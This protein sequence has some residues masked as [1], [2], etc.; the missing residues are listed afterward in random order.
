MNRTGV[1]RIKLIALSI[2]LVA[3]GVSAVLI[4]RADSPRF[5]QKEADSMPEY[6]GK[7]NA[8][9]FP[10]GMEWL[11]TDHPISL[12]Q[13]RGKVV[14]LDFWTYCCINCMH[15]LPD[16]KKLERKY[17]NELVVIGVHSAKFATEK[18]TENI[19]QA[20]L[21]Y[22]I[23]HPVVNDKD[24]VIWQH[25]A[26]RAWPTL[27]VIDPLGKIIGYVSGEG[28]Y[29]AFDQLIGQVVK[30]FDPRGLMNHEPIRFNLER[31]HVPASIL[32]FPGKVLADE[33]SKRLFIADSNHN[34]IVVTALDGEIQ[35]VIGKGE[36]GFDDGSFETATLNHPQGMALDGQWL[37]I[38]DT[39]NHAL[40]RADLI[41]RTLTTIAG[42]GHQSREFNVSGVGP[43]VSLNSPWDLV[44]HDGSLY[45]AMAGPHQI[46][47]MDLKTGQIGPYAGSGR[48]ARID[49]A[50][51]QAALAQ[52]S[53]I[54]TD[55]QK[56]Y[57]ADS[58]VSSIRSADL[59]PNGRVETIVGLDLFE[60]GDR[61]GTGSQVRL[62][63]PLGVIY[64]NGALY[65]ADT[66][67]NKIKQV[68]P[69]AKRAA[70]FLGTGQAGLRD[71]DGNSALFDEPGGVCA[72]DGKLYLADTN[73]HVIR[74]ADL[75][76]KKVSTLELK[77]IEKLPARMPADKFPGETV[78]LDAQTV[79]SGAGTL[80]VSLQLPEGY[81]LNDQAPTQVV[82]SSDGAK[83]RFEDGQ[84]EKTI[85]NPHFPL[86][87]PIQLEEGEAKLRAM[88]V[89]YYCEAKKES[90]CY[91]KVA[92]VRA[93]IKA[94]PEAQTSEVKVAY[95]LRAGA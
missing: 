29:E 30:E 4:N 72:A 68:S 62:Q 47:K 17:R 23:E 18:D 33:T 88:M 37:Y 76:T 50:L 85:R 56:L 7:V 27:F 84:W 21:R 80:M 2:V 20:I 57:F 52:P 9:D 60:F 63:H 12:K 90:L 35:D 39:E 95:T 45:M 24:M 51:R 83:V 93:P 87:V 69:Q 11:N 8:P 31:G 25:Y 86:N 14:V 61:D 73:N 44:L 78:T 36:I 66:Y 13:L 32:S 71:G 28:I 53:G 75:K 43:Q 58:E 26:V 79:K 81:K 89:I 1:N 41:K 92:E 34:R 3:L 74:V 16:L 5:D 6:E 38:A 82:L 59:N 67:N 22:E 91:F 19:R 70:T 10:G 46:W 65:V 55:G 48:E 54:T 77:G 42:T 94:Q 15:V 40:R 49:G 64:H